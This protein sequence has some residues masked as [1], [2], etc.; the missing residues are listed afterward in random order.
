[1][2][3]LDTLDRL[4]EEQLRTNMTEKD[5]KSQMK[6]LFASY[7]TPHRRNALSWLA[8]DNDRVTVYN[9]FQQLVQN[10]FVL[11]LNLIY[12]SHITIC[13]KLSEGL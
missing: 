13:E 10:L 4:V 2:I 3:S 8:N 5:A 11:F 12:E 6:T 1:M 9:V 7:K